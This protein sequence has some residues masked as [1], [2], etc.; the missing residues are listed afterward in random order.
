M[1]K[2]TIIL[3]RV[4]EEMVGELHVCNKYLRA[5]LTTDGS[6]CTWFEHL[7]ARFTTLCHFD[8]RFFLF[9]FTIFVLIESYVAWLLCFAVCELALATTTTSSS[10]VRVALLLDSWVRLFATHVSQVVGVSMRKV[11]NIG[12]NEELLNRPCE[13]WLVSIP[14]Q[15]SII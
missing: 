2:W 6:T 8:D 1:W 4:E 7:P 9:F 5:R 11:D 12:V 14:V 13:R 3:M 15:S 10:S